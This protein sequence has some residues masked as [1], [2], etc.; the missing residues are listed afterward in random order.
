MELRACKF[1]YARNIPNAYMLTKVAVVCWFILDVVYNKHLLFL[2]LVVVSVDDDVHVVPHSDQ[3]AVVRFERFLAF[4]EAEV[5]VHVFREIAWRFYILPNLQ[6]HSVPL[7]I[8]QILDH[9][10][11]LHTNA[12]M[13]DSLVLH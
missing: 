7:H 4:W 6:K 8:L 10:H 12:C 2:D 1:E 3:V 11:A 13:L 5:I 9:T